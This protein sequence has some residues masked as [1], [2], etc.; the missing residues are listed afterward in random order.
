MK[1]DPDGLKIFGSDEYPD[2]FISQKDA[3]KLNQPYYFTG[4]ACLHGHICARNTKWGY[5]VECRREG[6]R[7]PSVDRRS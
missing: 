5:C 1:T 7:K 3:S 2:E 6:Q 4:I